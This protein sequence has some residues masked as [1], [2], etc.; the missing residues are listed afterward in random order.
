MYHSILVPLDGSPAGEHALPFALSIARHGDVPI[1]LLHVHVPL[2]PMYA[3]AAAGLEATLDP[4]IREQEQAYL[5]GIA[6]RLKN[7]SSSRIGVRLVDG[8][9][10]DSIRDWA[11]SRA[12]D[13]IVMTTHGRGPL[14]R[15]WLGSVADQLVR[16]SP[17]PVLLVPPHGNVSDLP[18][19]PVRS[20]IL[21]PLDGAESAE[22]V[23]EPAISVGRLMGAVY[24]LLR[25]V[26]PLI[27]VGYDPVTIAYEVQDE[28]A[29][30]QKRQDAQI[31][32]D[33]V[34]DRLRQ[35]SLQINTCV[36]V[37]H[38]PA[39]VILEQAASEGVTLI[40]L[41][42]Q[43]RRGLSRVLLGSVADKVI[44]GATV[45]VLVLRPK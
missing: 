31:Y 28:H 17:V 11:Q 6:H 26:E 24:T 45:P 7:H 43:G 12:T 19:E 20:H 36:R 35:Q 22:Q 5:D 4:R 41:Q 15:F 44:R 38:Q 10:V 37:G 2:A 39:A 9:V 23:I 13:L 27:G 16:R 42:T 34:A 40:A 30:A 14:S 21:I 32:L 3:E 29:S 18:N 1:D 25:V 8:R 33:R